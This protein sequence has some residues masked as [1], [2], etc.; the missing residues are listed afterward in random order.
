M[1]WT[2]VF[3]LPIQQGVKGGA[4]AGTILVMAGFFVWAGELVLAVYFF[5]SVFLGV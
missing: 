3:A 4:V 2:M 1:L 5:R